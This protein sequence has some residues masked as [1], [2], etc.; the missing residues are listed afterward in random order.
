M[1]ASWQYLVSPKVGGKG[2]KKSGLG[3]EYWKVLTCCVHTSRIVLPRKGMAF[4]LFHVDFVPSW[5]LNRTASGSVLVR[6]SDPIHQVKLSQA[7]AV[8][9]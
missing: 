4:H 1:L 3:Q 9:G 5:P 2:K 7:A 8:S 6:V